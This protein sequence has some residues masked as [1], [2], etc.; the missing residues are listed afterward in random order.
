MP[1]KNNLD[2]VALDSAWFSIQVFEIAPDNPRAFGHDRLWRLDPWVT[3]EDKREPLLSHTA[4]DAKQPAQLER[5]SPT[6]RV[7]KR[8]NV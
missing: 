1:N 2:A 3:I 8:M 6:Y 5:G 4:E 7:T